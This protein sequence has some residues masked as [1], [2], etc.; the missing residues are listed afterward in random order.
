MEAG[1]IV[2]IVLASLILALFIFMLIRTILK[3]PINPESTYQ[4]PKVDIDALT[5]KLQGAVRIKTVTKLKPE[6]SQE[7]F[8]EYHKYLFKTFPEIFKIA[9]VTVI[10]KYS[11]IIK[12]TG[13]D[14]SLLPVAFLAHQDV[15]PATIDGWEVDP[16]SAE[17]KDGCVYGRGSQDMKSQM[18]S[19]LN[20]LEVLLSEKK[21]PE[22]TI[23]YCF[24]H[25]E[26]ITGMEGAYNIAKFLE[27]QNIQFEYML[28]E[29]GTITNGRLL[30]IDGKIALI[31]TCDK[32]YADYKISAIKDGGHG[33]SPKKISS[34]DMIAKAITK[35]NKHPMK[36]Y[37]SIPIRITFKTLAPYMKP[38]Y[39]FLFINSDILAP[40]LKP[41]LTRINPL[42]NSIL[43][44]TIAF[45]MMN[46]AT[47]ANVIPVKSSA[48]MNVRINPGQTNADVLHH[49][50]K[51]LGKDY[52]VEEYNMCFEPT[53]ISPSDGDKIYETIKESIKDIYHGVIVSSYPFIG[54]TDSKHYGKLSDH[55][56]RFTPFEV[57]ETDQKRIHGLNERCHIDRLYLAH[58]FFRRLI[59][60]TC[61]NINDKKE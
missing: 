14:S 10:N 39:K 27:D 6:D 30:G 23:Y 59:E 26:E 36:A 51:V 25:D 2:L 7:S 17:I 8:L 57:D 45:T 55:I 52:I 11:L 13:T 21:F 42:T 48:V 53:R 34:V 9:E 18:I 61:Y 54:A 38:L 28:D 22:R 44:T 40:L 50:K 41:V 19:V 20:A 47:A 43:R 58:Q 46:G 12:I 32:G 56:Y 24:G 31:G 16:F 29:G 15:V 33:S 5:E 4:A 60:K 1:Y 37:R 35:L 3:K 49:I